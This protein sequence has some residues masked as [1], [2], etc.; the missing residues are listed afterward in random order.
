MLFSHVYLGRSYSGDDRKVNAQN[1]EEG[2][3]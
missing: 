1:Q 3:R 2:I